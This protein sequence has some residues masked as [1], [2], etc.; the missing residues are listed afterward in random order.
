[1]KEACGGGDPWAGSE[2]WLRVCQG[3]RKEGTEAGRAGH[4]KTLDEAGDEETGGGK[5][6][7]GPCRGPSA[8]AAGEVGLRLSSPPLCP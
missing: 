6:G 3:N 7:S 5:G 8:D 1:M 2:G 4:H